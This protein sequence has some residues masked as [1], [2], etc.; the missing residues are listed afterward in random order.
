M[1]ADIQAPDSRLA[2]E[3]EE[4]ARSVSDDMLFNHV[5][6]CYWFSELFARQ[7]GLQIDRELVFLSSVLHDL[8]LTDHARGANRFEIEGADAARTFLLQQGISDE[9]AWHVWN[10]I[11][12]HVWDVNLFRD[13][14][15]KAM[16]LGLVHDVVGVPGAELDERDVAEVLRHYPRL[17]F[18][19]AFHEVL[20]NE[21]ESTSPYPHFFHICTYIEHAGAPL[22]LPAGSALI[23]GAPFDE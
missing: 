2:R 20:R 11:A 3:A 16:E 7:Q 1:I 9:R 19:R 6:R 15:S 14:S 8:G 5:M 13:D 23:E 21:L 17:D 12:L 4:L 10:D 22:T 18:K